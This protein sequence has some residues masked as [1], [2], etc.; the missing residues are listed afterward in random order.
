M[1]Q[2][3]SRKGTQR[4][5]GLGLIAFA[6]VLAGCGGGSTSPVTSVIALESP[7]IAADGVTRPSVRCGLGPIWMTLEWEELPEETKEIAIYFGRFKYVKARGGRKLVL[8][9]A[10]LLSKIKP[11]MR[12]LPANVVPQGASWSNIAGFSCP[13]AKTGQNLLIEVFALDRVHER[14]MK[15]RL[16][17]RLTEEALKDPHPSESPRSP[18]KLTGD[19]A[20]IGRM[21]AT[22]GPPQ[23]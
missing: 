18:G 12:R 3:K 10:D 7:G 15:R 16:A 5:W 4:A 9:Y 6:L 20:A 13:A 22:Y 19:T 17:T 8:T 21:I 14:E 1:I 23:S 2:E 11:T